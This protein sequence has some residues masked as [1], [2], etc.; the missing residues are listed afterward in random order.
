MV[1]D[2][3][4]AEGK[5]HLQQRRMGQALKSFSTCLQAADLTPTTQGRTLFAMGNLYSQVSHFDTSAICF[6]NTARMSPPDTQIHEL[7]L[8]NL[9]MIMDQKLKFPSNHLCGLLNDGQLSATYQRA[10]RQVID[11]ALLERPQAQL[12]FISYG[13]TAWLQAMWV[14]NVAR[15]LTDSSGGDGCAPKVTSIAVCTSLFMQTCGEQAAQANGLSG[16]VVFVTLA[17]SADVSSLDLS[18]HLVTSR[19]EPADDSGDPADANADALVFDY[20]MF[21]CGTSADSLSRL[22][23]LYR[24]WVRPGAPVL[25]AHLSVC[26]AIVES[27]SIVQQVGRSVGRSVGR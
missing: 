7:S 19:P 12:N 15:G 2:E 25:P 6:L 23:A 10:A 5:A 14:A 1:A 9:R 22:G 24:R 18:P 4:Y 16:S 21:P 27:E 3:L 17:E 11:A 26:A 20:D 13:K 8:Q